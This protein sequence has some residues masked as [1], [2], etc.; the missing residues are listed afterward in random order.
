MS[1]TRVGFLAASAAALAFSILVSGSTHAGAEPSM[2]AAP[3]PSFVASDTSDDHV[4]RVLAI[5][6]DGLNPRAITQLG[7]TG[8]PAFHRMMRE[9]VSTLNAR[10]VLG[11]TNTLPNHTTMLTSRRLDPAYGG[12]GVRFN[13]DNGGTVEKAAGRY[14]PSM[15]DVV[16]DHGGSTALYSSSGGFRFFVRTWNTNGDPDNV[17]TDQGRAKIDKVNINGNNDA[18]VENLVA[19][20]NT[21]P[22]TLSF[23]RIALPDYAGHRH[24]FMS[25]SYLDAVKATDRLLASLLVTV[26]AKSSLREHTL[27]VLTADHGGHGRDHDDP[28]DLENYRIPFMAW[29]AGIPAGRDLYDINPAFKSPGMSRPGYEGEQ[30]IRNGALGNL[31]TDVLDMPALGGSEF[32]RAQDLNVF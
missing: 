4:D 8:A 31:A 7:R 32:N 27:V 19:E 12:H 3:A 5:S 1:H 22:K 21:R 18:L 29:G 13:Y 25:A 9:G 14:V 2:P 24:G 17:G 28:T 26:T 6:V 16:H 10:T 30:P 23:L 15:F 20:L 11:S